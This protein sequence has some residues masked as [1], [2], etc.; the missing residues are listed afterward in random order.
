MSAADDNITDTV[1]APTQV[2]SLTNQLQT[3]A[4][5]AAQIPRS[6]GGT[7]LPPYVPL[8]ISI[9]HEGDGY[10]FT[11]IQSGLTAVPDEM[12]IGATWDPAQAEAQAGWWAA[13]FRPSE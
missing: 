9:S 12:A 6:Q 11:D 8:L 5:A 10:P 3:A 7:D 2:L 4:A 1:Q 13:S